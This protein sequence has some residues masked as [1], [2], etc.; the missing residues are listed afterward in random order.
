[1]NSVL[2][3]LPQAGELIFSNSLLRTLSGLTDMAVAHLDAPHGRVVFST[4]MGVVPPCAQLPSAQ[5]AGPMT[6]CHMSEMTHIDRIKLT[7]RFGLA[8]YLTDIA[9][10]FLFTCKFEGGVE[11]HIVAALPSAIRAQGMMGLLS[12]IWPI[13]REDCLSEMQKTNED[14][15][16]KAML[17]MISSKIDVA[18][19]IMNARGV[20]LRAN[21]SAKQLLAMKIMLHKT[22]NGICCINDCQTRQFRAALAACARSEP[23]GAEAVFFMDTATPGLRIPVTLSR[24][25]HEGAAT[26]LVTA[27]MPTPPDSRRVERL[28][29]AF[30][31]TRSEA[32]VAALM[33]MGLSN[34]DAA[35]IAGLKEQSVATY[36]KRILNKL[37]VT[38]RAEMAQMLTWQA[39]GGRL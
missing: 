9:R 22:P 25:W 5:N 19:M 32:R 37:N 12:V 2:G 3:P 24:F 29:R 6:V 21:A 39:A 10:C 26:D 18:I 15:C 33:Q 35:L 38:S 11:D 17:W 8:S 30:G 14:F 7:E 13:L 1:M 36:A 16:D 20:M 34:K 31:L 28:A 27:M 4:Q 23:S